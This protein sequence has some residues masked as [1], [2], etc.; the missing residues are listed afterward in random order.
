PADAQGA[1][2]ARGAHAA[3]GWTRGKRGGA[4][5]GRLPSRLLGRG[6]VRSTRRARRRRAP[7]LGRDGA[8]RRREDVAESRGELEPRPVREKTLDDRLLGLDGERLHLRRLQ[9]RQDEADHLGVAVEVLLLLG[10]SDLVA[11]TELVDP[12]PGA[13]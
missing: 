5:R 6:L 10:S 3:P 2:R 12:A 1:R 13:V 7:S 11:V 8:Q 4:S 9:R